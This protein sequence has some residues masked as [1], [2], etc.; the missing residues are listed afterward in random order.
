MDDCG[1]TFA[2]DTAVTCE[3]DTCM[4][5]EK[6]TVVASFV[7][8]KYS[9]TP[10]LGAWD[11]N[12]HDA[13]VLQRRRLFFSKKFVILDV[14]CANVLSAGGT[15]VFLGLLV[16]K[17]RCATFAMVHVSTWKLQGSISGA[18]RTETNSAHVSKNFLVL[19]VAEF[20]SVADFLKGNHIDK[21]VGL[22][23]KPVIA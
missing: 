23:A 5:C 20:G 4:T 11:R 6:D 16:T 18:N 3:K 12:P 17:P 19:L 7:Q 15:G 10:S 2:C 13:F 14:L 1:K 22:D 21:L 8:W 9:G